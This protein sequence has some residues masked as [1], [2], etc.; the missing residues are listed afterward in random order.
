MD[1]PRRPIRIH[2]TGR[3]LAQSRLRLAVAC[4]VVRQHPD[5]S[6]DTHPYED[7]A[8]YARGRWE[9][10]PLSEA[11][12]VVHALPYQNG[13]ET[14]QV[15][16]EAEAA[17]LPCIFFRLTDDPTPANPP[18]GVVYRTSL[19]RDRRTPREFASPAIT[20][21]LLVECGGEIVVRD[22]G[23]R[24]VVGFCGHVGTPRQRLFRRAAGALLGGGQRDKATGI[25]LRAR[26]L[27][28]LRSSDRI[29]P[30]L[31]ERT[32]I[33]GWAS[34]DE[35]QD[36][37]REKLRRDFL[38]NLLESDYGLALR[39]KGNYSFRLYEI[40]SLGRVPLF[41]DTRCVLPF[42]DEIDW[43]RHCIWVD[44]SEVDRIDEVVAQFHADL[45]PD[46]Y[47]QLQLDNRQLWLD[48]LSPA[49]IYTKILAR[50]LETGSASATG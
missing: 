6:P 50:A 36:T 27:K 26:A 19:Y 10:S 18:Y 16:R 5:G 29:E 48:A 2:F 28:A 37:G 31:I 21:D 15:A 7:L 3:D 45:H 41:V 8:E 23:E 20:E 49:A 47:R 4:G 17:G 40:F 30:R 13:A 43:K 9:A 24:A 33:W 1:E 35:A 22:K 44:E 25:V 32:Q 42:E 34:T 14:E 38:D 12:V 11:D 46:D 39:G